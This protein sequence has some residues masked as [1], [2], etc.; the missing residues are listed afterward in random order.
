[1]TLNVPIKYTHILIICNSVS[2]FVFDWVAEIYFGT[3]DVLTNIHH[4]VSIVSS[5]FLFYTNYGGAELLWITLLGEISNPSLVSRTMLKIVEGGK[6]STFFA[7]N[8]WVF[9]VTFIGSRLIV[10]PIFIWVLFAQY[11]SPIHLKFGPMF[12]MFIS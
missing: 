4:A 8:E 6:D 3:I 5:S 12:V 11:N 2:Y 7:I 10:S 1:M 9:V